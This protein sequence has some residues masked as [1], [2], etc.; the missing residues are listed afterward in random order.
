MKLS[1]VSRYFDTIETFDAYTRRLLYLTQPASFENGSVEGSTSKRRVLSMAPELVPPARRCVTLLGETWVVGDG[2]HDGL[3]N[4]SLRQSFWMRK[5][6]A[7]YTFQTPGQGALNT[8]GSMAYALREYLK[9][10]VNASTDAEYDPQY[11]LSFAVGESVVKG[12]VVRTASELY[13]VRSVYLDLG[14][15][16]VAV[17]D[18][19]AGSAVSAVFQGA[20]YT[21]ATD[22]WSGSTVTTGALLIEFVKLFEQR[23]PADSP[24]LA[25]DRVML[26]ATSAVTP[27][28]GQR[29]TAG[30]QLWEVLTVTAYSDAWLLHLRST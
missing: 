7:L 8:G 3:F 11:L 14:G 19:I 24:Y 18:D 21:P 12:G 15:F 4:E 13:H 30:G 6:S 10:T 22:V 1:D 16:K 2:S 5:A 25:G 20:T 23:T 17:C 9:D 27:V 28:P 29:V 26:A